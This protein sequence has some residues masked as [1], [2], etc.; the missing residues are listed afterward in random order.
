[1][2]TKKQSTR[3]I[4]W[5][6]IIKAD[7]SFLIMQ[8]WRM[9]NKST[10]MIDGTDSGW[11]LEIGVIGID[12]TLKIIRHSHFGP[13][14]LEVLLRT[15]SNTGLSVQEKMSNLPF[16]EIPKSNLE[17]QGEISDAYDDFIPALDRDEELKKR[18]GGKESRKPLHAWRLNLETYKIIKTGGVGYQWKLFN[19][20]KAESL[21]LW[22]AIQVLRGD[23]KSMPKSYRDKI[24]QRF[25]DQKNQVKVDQIIHECLSFSK[26]NKL[27]IE[28][29]L[30]GLKETLKNHDKKRLDLMFQMALLSDR[31][32]KWGKQSRK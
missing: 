9:P 27:R 3:S 7:P 28:K 4:D 2:A 23:R 21:I 13:L 32:K 15:W 11:L 24:T 12:K 16:R 6:A 8:G 1:M 5:T 25:Y 26:G 10:G 30:K 29:Q 20:I 31:L 18:K 17:E 22:D 19:R 14:E